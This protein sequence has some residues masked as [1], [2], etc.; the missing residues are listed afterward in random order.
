M[1]VN[2]K[3]TPAQLGLMKELCSGG[4]IKTYAN[5]SGISYSTAET[6]RRNV[7]KKLGVQTV[8]HAVAILVSNPLIE[9]NQRL[10]RRVTHLKAVGDLIVNGIGGSKGSEIAKSV[11]QQAMEAK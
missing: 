5:K 10:Q 3:L 7:M 4:T 11:W 2:S 8:N 1:C 6:H 9:S